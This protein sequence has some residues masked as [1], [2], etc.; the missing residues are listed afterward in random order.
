MES[1]RPRLD[2]SEDVTRKMSAPVSSSALDSDHSDSASFLTR[3]RITIFAG[4]LF[5]AAAVFF[6]GDRFRREREVDDIRTS[7]E[8]LAQDG[9]P[10]EALRFALTR[11]AQWHDDV[12]FTRRY[13]DLTREICEPLLVRTVE[14][15]ALALFA[16]PYDQID[17]GFMLRVERLVPLLDVRPTASLLELACAQDLV[18]GR[19]RSPAAR[20]KH[21]GAIPRDGRLLE[22]EALAA[23][24]MNDVAATQRAVAALDEKPG[25][26]DDVIEIAVRALRL[27]FLRLRIRQARYRDEHVD[28]P[29]ASDDALDASEREVLAR[30]RPAHP[31]LARL[32]L[33]FQ[34]IVQS[35]FPAAAEH[36]RALATGEKTHP[37]ADDFRTAA[38]TGSFL[39]ASSQ[40]LAA[41]YG[42]G[43]WPAAWD[44]TFSL[45][46]PLFERDTA[47]LAAFD[48][49]IVTQKTFPFGFPESR[50][51][52]DEDPKR[53]TWR[54]AY[55]LARRIFEHEWS[56]HPAF[57]ETLTTI[58][59]R[60]VSGARAGAK[61]D[62][63][64]KIAQAFE[65]FSGTE[66]PPEHAG[67]N[68]VFFL[69][70]NHA[71]AALD[72]AL[73]ALETDL[74]FGDPLA[75]ARIREAM[76]ALRPEL[77]HSSSVEIM[78]G[79]PAFGFTRTTLTGL[80]AALDRSSSAIGIEDR[81]RA[82]E[83]LATWLNQPEATG[84]RLDAMPAEVRDAPKT[85]L[86]RA[87]RVRE[88][89]DEVGRRH[90]R[91]R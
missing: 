10:D 3:H 28:W 12:D 42:R 79:H 5:L 53:R 47:S 37:P 49:V 25:P 36:A 21:H 26:S 45:L 66:R 68:D 78:R 57:G 61:N 29:P 88:F 44:E 41:H 31:E 84:D 56:H 24:R 76:A 55:E 22:L 80:A 19:R 58:V 75:T 62:L 16:F 89:L 39:A 40:F 60:A 90:E 83:A 77:E 52:F 35:R 17:D 20:L 81:R 71:V 73:D 82:R 72:L 59:G 15:M 63:A 30:V 50:E 13:D 11:Q 1:T 7:M 54:G 85:M 43:G 9:R 32:V 64:A 33:W 34:S 91:E 48:R 70:W 74:S 4:F 14:V 38:G 87:R 8:Q 18:R 69:R 27:P 86:D 23:V 65:E 2:D 51:W 67:G 6:F 46:V